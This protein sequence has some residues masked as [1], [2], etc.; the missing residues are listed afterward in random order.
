MVA[1]A[2][3]DSVYLTDFSVHHLEL[4]GRKPGSVISDHVVSQLVAYEHQY[5]C[6]FVGA[7]L[8]EELIEACPQLG[9]RLW[10]ELD[11]VPISMQAVQQVKR[12]SV[13][14]ATA[15]KD[16]KYW[17][18]K[19]VDEQADSMAR[20]CIMFFG[21]RMTPL[22]QVG[23]EGIV[24]VDAGFRTHMCSLEDYQHTCGETT[25]NA[26]IKYA[27]ELKAK[28]T[29]IAF[30]SATPQGGGVA[31]MR[32]ALVRFANVLGV[33][34]KWYVPKPKPG[35]FRIT[36]N[37]HNTLQGVSKPG[38]FISTE[39]KEMLTEWID[40]NA[41]RYWLPGSGPLSDPSEGGADIIVVRSPPC[42]TKRHNS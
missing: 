30:F 42:C 29:K 23:F 18:I 34:L 33:D 11:I 13:E 22:L 3:H 2:I 38:E 7:G 20:K 16:E 28:R 27:S 17:N 4:H 6:K 40:D 32:H 14:A 19:C 12:E 39:N 37:V 24:Q 26:V 25:W 41:H 15:K 36:K 31:L 5:F 1:I 8:P 10:A 9:P 21:P 35:V